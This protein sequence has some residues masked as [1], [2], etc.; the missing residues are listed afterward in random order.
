MPPA[1]CTA[2][3][4]VLEGSTEPPPARLKPTGRIVGKGTSGQVGE[5][6]LISRGKWGWLRVAAG[7]KE[8]PRLFEAANKVHTENEVNLLTTGNMHVIAVCVCVCVLVVLP[9]AL[10]VLVV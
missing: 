3:T 7:K 2:S 9:L 6:S 5:V 1:S 10:C 8:P 4:R